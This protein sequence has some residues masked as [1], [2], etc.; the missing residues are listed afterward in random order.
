[1]LPEFAPLTAYEGRHGI[2]AVQYGAAVTDTFP[3]PST[4]TRRRR[5]RWLLPAAAAAVLLAGGAAVYVLSDE[6]SAATSSPKPTSTAAA[7]T[8]VGTLTLNDSDGFTFASD[9]GCNGT[10][11]YDEIRAGAQV[12]ITDGAG[13]TVAL[14]QLGSGQMDGTFN[15]STAEM[16]KFNFAV[17]AVPTGKGFYGVEI[18]HRGRVQYPEQ[19][20]F[21]AL[22]LTLG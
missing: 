12:V 8:V 15:S 6:E 7:R 17:P 2:D 11:G 18:A 5:P 13:T 19:Q 10:G 14:G 16:C 4:P 21:G 20:L 9:S 3:S 1:M 22:A